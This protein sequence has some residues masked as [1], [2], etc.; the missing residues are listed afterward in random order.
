MTTKTLLVAGGSH[1][2]IPV[3]MAAKAH[4]YRVLTSGNRPGDY[5]HRYGDGAYLEDFS[6]YGKMLDLARRLKVDAICP[7]ANDFSMISAAYVA[8]KLGLPGFDSF[9]TTLRLH[10]KDSFRA[11]GAEI[12]LDSPRALGFDSPDI[13]AA[14]IADLVFPLI[15]KPIDLTG[16]KGISRVDC[17]EQLRAAIDLAF[18][19]SR[20][21]RV[22]IEEFFHGTLHSYSS[23][24]CDKK[25][26]F[27]FADNEYSYL[28][29][30]TVTTSTSPALVSPEVLKKVRANTE[31]LARTLRLHDGILHAQFLAS[32][33]DCRIIEY[34]RRSPGD[35]Y[36]FPVQ[37]TSG[38][39]YADLIVRPY[40]GLPIT[41][42]ER[43]EKTAYYSRHCLLAAC[44]GVFTDI[45]IDPEIA[46][47]VREQIIV[48]QPGHQVT[49]YLSERLGV[50]FLEYASADEMARKTARITELIRVKLTDST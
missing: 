28:N 29:P 6:D 14:D 34:T 46:A 27:E 49:N 18:E 8:E 17:P 25:V 35:L 38:V 5:G 37:A 26:V 9:Q 3:I 2:D 15:V 47:N 36:A 42:P 21:K 45:D 30:Y 20:A 31:L 22:V 19:F 23:I 39:D 24:I 12:G 16:G 4:G 32:G 41:P 50:I 33:Q 40:L 13:T 44:N 10:H 11:L 48:A 1:S 43:K 7:S